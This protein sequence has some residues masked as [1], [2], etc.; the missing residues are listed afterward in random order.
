MQ[1]EGLRLGMGG[2]HSARALATEWY[3]PPA[4]FEALGL[5]FDLDPCAPAGGLPWIPA[6]RFLS[7]DDD[8]LS[9]PW[10]GRV[11]LNPP[12]GRATAAWMRRLAAHGDGVA[13][14]FARTDTA[15]FHEVATSAHVICFIAGRL[16]FVPASPDQRN[17][18]R[19]N[20][21]SGAPSMLMAFG[22][23]CGEVV[24]RA[25]L[26]M[27]FGVCARPLLGQASLWEDERSNAPA[28]ISA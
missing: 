12:Y 7:I 3:T 27:V 6:R 24:A 15:W 11:W 2:H 14:V 16:T 18:E 17:N 23:E 8:G 19:S 21:N 26:G 25:G 13:L 28:T 4:I 1:D 10:E 22:E 20:F 5:E 9:H